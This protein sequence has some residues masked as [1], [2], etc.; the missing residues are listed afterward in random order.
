MATQSTRLGSAFL[1]V[2]GFVGAGFVAAPGTEVLKKVSSVYNGEL[3]VLED[4][5][6]GAR[7]LLAQSRQG[8]VLQSRI[9][10]TRKQELTMGYFQVMAL[11]TGLHPA[12]EHVFNMGLGGGA[13]PRFHLGRYPKSEV[14][15]VEI[16]PAVIDLAKQYFYVTDNRHR[17]VEG[18]GFEIL[19]LQP[20]KFDVVWVD[21]ITPKEGPKAYIPAKYLNVLK[22]HLSDGGIIVANL[23]EWRNPESFSGVERSYRQ[24]YEHG[25]RVKSPLPLRDEEPGTVLSLVQA[26]AGETVP[27]LQPSYFVAVGNTASLSCANFMSLYKKWRATR[28]LAIE[29]KGDGI[30]KDL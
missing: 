7:F 14:V 1:L 21:T 12:P 30:C 23:G 20:G 22:D 9:D 18:D 28:T 13:L 29:W 10:L 26:S 27:E 15:S 19:K 2:L 5:A 17:I 24:G 4:E 6:H 3:T 8:L 16:D 11:L 25:I